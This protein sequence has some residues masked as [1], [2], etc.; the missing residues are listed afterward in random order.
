MEIPHPTTN[1]K[2]FFLKCNKISKKSIKERQR[3]RVSVLRVTSTLPNPLGAA[4]DV[5]ISD[6]WITNYTIFSCRSG[7]Y[8]YM[9]SSLTSIFSSSVS[10]SDSSTIM[11][12]LCTIPVEYEGIT[13]VSRAS[14][15]SI[16]SNSEVK[17]T[18][19]R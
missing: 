18:D 1:K 10:A 8:P 6:V 14:T 4:M 16:A 11:P 17:Y 19:L 13:E 7:R 9:L 5:S 12:S 15:S 2:Q 3:G